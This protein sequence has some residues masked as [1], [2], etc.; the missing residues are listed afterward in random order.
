MKYFT[1]FICALFICSI[2]DVS[3][4]KLDRQDL[5]AWCIVP[6]DSEKRTP[7]ERI[8][9]L[10]RLG[11]H[12]Y[13]YDWREEHLA[14]MSLEWSV[15]ERYDVEVS[16]VWMY[17]NGDRDTLGDLGELNERVFQTIERT[18]IKTDLWVSFNQNYFNEVTTGGELVKAAE[19]INYLAKRA[20][21][22][23]CR[24]G[25]YNHGG[26]WFGDPRNQIRIIEQLDHKNIGLVY[27]F[28][29]AHEQLEEFGQLVSD[30]L[31]YLWTVNLNGMRAGGPKI[32]AIG[33]GDREKD[34]VRSLLEKGYDGDF[35]IIGH[36]DTADVEVV[37]RNNL[38]G[39]TKLGLLA[40]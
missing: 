35:G 21:Q 29:H 26:D 14:E 20:A 28:H 40:E 25:L 4:Q 39:L 36:I 3:A 22:A 31:P 33:E 27:N 38:N 8:K 18:G 34:M 30:M 6:F 37:L 2:Q 5:L 11:L 16:A 24:I 12:R 9:M 13:A 23:G 10:R 32:L 1:L 19:M 17:I 7:L 15:A